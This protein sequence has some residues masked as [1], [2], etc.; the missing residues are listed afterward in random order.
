MKK[1]VCV[2]SALGPILNLFFAGLL[3]WTGWAWNG[4]VPGFP[5]WAFI[6]MGFIFLALVPSSFRWIVMDSE[7]F[8]VRNWR[9]RVRMDYE[10]VERV[11]ILARKIS[12]LTKSVAHYAALRSSDGRRT[13]LASWNFAFP[14]RCLAELARRI[15]EA[16]GEAPPV[17][18][19]PPDPPPMKRSPLLILLGGAMS[20]AGLA[21]LLLTART[22]L[23][24]GEAR[25]AGLAGE[26][27]IVSI[28]PEGE[29]PYWTLV[30][31]RIP[32][33]E[34]RKIPVQEAW[35]RGRKPGDRIAVKVHPSHP[36][37]FTPADE[38]S[39]A[40]SAFSSAAIALAFLALGG[41]TFVRSLTI[42]VCVTA[43]LQEAFGASRPG[44]TPSTERS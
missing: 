29:T 18:A 42:P 41:R 7:G 5:G 26:A 23:L 33:D 17:A 12:L 43:G 37:I 25:A 39:S 6:A 20:A 38:G 44:E 27:R 10:E 16:R 13:W 15:R 28:S 32:G 34:K 8:T 24:V 30:M 35:A 36:E 22:G 2:T 31:E 4:A 3:G 19:P 11:E 40:W 9:I 14:R 21:L 1:N